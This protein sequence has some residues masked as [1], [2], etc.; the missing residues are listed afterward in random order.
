MLELEQLRLRG[1]F[2]VALIEISPQRNLMSARFEGCPQPF[3]TVQSACDECGVP[4]IAV[5]E[6]RVSA[7]LLDARRRID[8]S[9]DMSSDE[10]RHLLSLI[11]MCAELWY[12]YLRK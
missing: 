10:A 11:R 3:K 8:V 5:L 9:S 1:S 4:N 2:G 6:E 7:L 12:A